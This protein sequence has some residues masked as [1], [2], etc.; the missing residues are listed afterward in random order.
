M[1]YNVI[2]SIKVIIF[3]SFNLPCGGLCRQIYPQQCS[4]SLFPTLKYADFG[5]FLRIYN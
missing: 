5:Y 4:F 1:L 3:Q 2:Y